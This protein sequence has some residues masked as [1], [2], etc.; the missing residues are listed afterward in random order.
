MTESSFK[1]RR[2]ILLA[3]LLIFSIVFAP[4]AACADFKAVE[5]PCGLEF[6]RDHASHHD[7]RTEWWYYTGNL[8]SDDGER[9][10]FQ[11]TFFR[12][13]ADARAEVDGQRSEWRAEHIFAAHAAVSDLTTGRFET[14]EK[15]SRAALGLAGTSRDEGFFEVFVNGWRAVI[16]PRTHKVFARGAGFSIDLDLIPEKPPSL[17]GDSGYSRKGKAATEA[18]C[19]YSITRMRTAGKITVGGRERT[20]S[21]TGWMD[22]EFSSASLNPEIAGW[23]WFSLRLSDGSDLMVYLMREKDGGFSSVSSGTYVDSG[24]TVRHLA[25]EDLRVRPLDTWKSPR[26]G[27]SYP[28]RWLLEVIPVDLRLEIVPNM[29]DQEVRSPESTRVTY[30]EGSVSAKGSKEQGT[31]LSGEGYV[32][33]TGYA[34]PVVY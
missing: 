31:P 26:S 17:H 9:F 13:A 18:S 23:D 4:F 24:G 7:Y 34:G 20:V 14:A 21:G 27:A 25:F 19:Y 22:H 15:M 11:V 29:N 2:K 32:E 8:R 6:P 10:G 28:S 3:V 1:W 30:W 33:L 16:T 12:V 5:G